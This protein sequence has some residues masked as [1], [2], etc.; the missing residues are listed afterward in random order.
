MTRL[1]RRAPDVAFGHRFRPPPY[2]GSNQFL[3]ALRRELG[4]R[5]RKTVEERYATSVVARRYLDLLRSL[6]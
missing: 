5:A 3:L 6:A 1:L 2:G 4:E